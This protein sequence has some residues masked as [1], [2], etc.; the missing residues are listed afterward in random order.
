M[1]IDEHV[2]KAK[3]YMEAGI[4]NLQEGKEHHQDARTRLCIII[5]LCVVILVIILSVALF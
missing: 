3:E 2:I 5:V 1:S 4:K